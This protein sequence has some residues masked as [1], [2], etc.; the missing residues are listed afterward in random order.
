MS[1]TFCPSRSQ[2]GLTHQRTFCKQENV[3]A[4]SCGDW[5]SYRVRYLN[6]PARGSGVLS[7]IG[8]IGT[9]YCEKL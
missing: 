5:P 1:S 8:I 2:Y 3:S 7:Q 9:E 4:L 6:G